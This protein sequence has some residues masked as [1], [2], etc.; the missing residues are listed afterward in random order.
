M[1]E[2]PDLAVFK[3]N[4]KNKVLDKKITSTGTH[5]SKSLINTDLKTVAKTLIGQKFTQISQRGKHI[6]FQTSNNYYVIFHLMLRG[7]FEYGKKLET[8]SFL[9]CFWFEFEDGNELRIKDRTHWAKLE[10][11]Q[12]LEESKLLNNLGP[13]ADKVNL[14]EFKKTLKASRLGRIKPLL[15]DQKKIAGIGNAYADEILWASEIHPERSASLLSDKEIGNLHKNIKKVLLWGRKKSSSDVGEGFEESQRDWMN[16]Y[17]K[18]GQECPK[19][20]REI[21]YMKV[22]GR[23]TFYCGKCQKTTVIKK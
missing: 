15:M 16:V 12:D 18:K 21:L 19:C 23:D 3:K 5:A 2:L 4:L 7:R 9:Y 13:D 22:N 8:H 6:V 1:P 11:I 14:N 10:L 17:R 20:G